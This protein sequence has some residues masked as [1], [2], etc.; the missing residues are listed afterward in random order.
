M[1]V[2]IVVAVWII[3][4]VIIFVM[5]LG[6]YVEPV[7]ALSMSVWWPIWAVRILIKTLLYSITKNEKWL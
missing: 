6:E 2:G 1:T 3:V 7:I 4:A 5:S